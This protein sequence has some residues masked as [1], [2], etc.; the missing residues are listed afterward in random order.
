MPRDNDGKAPA[1]TRNGA[2]T[3]DDEKEEEEGKNGVGSRKAEDAG[4]CDGLGPKG[5]AEDAIL[6]S[7]A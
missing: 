3:A 7:A 1:P 4:I 5:N 2:A 6:S